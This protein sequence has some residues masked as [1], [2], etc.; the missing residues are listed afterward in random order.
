MSIDELLGLPLLVPVPA[1]VAVTELELELAVERALARR[2]PVEP[3]APL[4]PEPLPPLLRARK[5]SAD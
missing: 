1:P 2:F 3:A 4:P 5:R